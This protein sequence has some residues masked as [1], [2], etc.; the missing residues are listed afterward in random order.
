MNFK[1][2]ILRQ[3][4]K[5]APDIAMRKG[6]KN[7]FLVERKDPLFDILVVGQRVFLVLVVDGD[8]SQSE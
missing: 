5:K 2:A 4:M 3:V 7:F 8:N 1:I 6:P